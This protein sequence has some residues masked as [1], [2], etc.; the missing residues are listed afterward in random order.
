M[1]L[2]SDIF[3][4][5]F[6]ND[7]EKGNWLKLVR[8]KCLFDYLKTLIEIETVVDVQLKRW[9]HFQWGSYIGDFPLY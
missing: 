4:K 9:F 2:S 6:K 8:D 5:Y 7:Q 1:R 3:C